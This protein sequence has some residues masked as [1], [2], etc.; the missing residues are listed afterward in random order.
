MT[1]RLD[2]ELAAMD[3]RIERS[4][5]C[6]GAELTYRIDYRHLAKVLQVRPAY[7]ATKPRLKYV[8]PGLRIVR[9]PKKDVEGVLPLRRETA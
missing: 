4:D 6:R 3:G 9:A 8:I 1:W 7:L 5:Q 2:A